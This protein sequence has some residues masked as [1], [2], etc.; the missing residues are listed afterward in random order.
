M[1]ARSPSWR[2]RTSLSILKA[3]RS[4]AINLHLPFLDVALPSL[5]SQFSTR[6]NPRDFLHQMYTWR[7][8]DLTESICQLGVSTERRP[9]KVFQPLPAAA[10]AGT[11]NA[12]N[13]RNPADWETFPSHGQSIHLLLWSLNIHSLSTYGAR[14]EAFEIYDDEKEYISL[15]DAV[16]HTH[17]HTHTHSCKYAH[18]QL[19]ACEA[20]L[21]FP[22]CNAFHK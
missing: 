11:G 12:M 18:I 2:L 8:S 22:V 3:L 6:R 15:H 21:C 14:A 16:L 1:P 10:T 19:K 20:M 7:N 13:L 5:P 9:R 4:P 17:T